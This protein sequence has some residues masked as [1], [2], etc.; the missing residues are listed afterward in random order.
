MIHLENVSKVYP[1]PDGLVRALDDINLSVE[2]GDFVV[3]RGPSG[4]GKSTLLLTIGGLVTPTTGKIT[5]EDNDLYAMPRR[6]RARFRAE[7]VGFVFQMFHLLPYLDA[8][9]NVLVAAVP[10]RRRGARRD[11]IELLNRLQMSDRLH[12]FPGE[13]STG[14]RQ[15]VAVARAMLTE[16]SIILADEPTGNLDPDNAAQVLRHLAEFHRAGG[17]VLLVT[18]EKAADDLARKLVQLEAGR[19]VSTQEKR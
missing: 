19:I 5:V 17:T 2:R 14:E 9:Q 10:G 11:A 7:N 6:D 12:H 3:V 18:H 16:P 8:L 1:G 15:R 4:S 13:L